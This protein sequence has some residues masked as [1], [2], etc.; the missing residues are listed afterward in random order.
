M[1]NVDNY[2]KLLLLSGWLNWIYFLL[3]NLIWKDAISLYLLLRVNQGNWLLFEKLK[4]N[5]SLKRKKQSVRVIREN[6]CM[7][8]EAVTTRSSRSQM[9]FKI[10]VLENFAIFTGKHPCW[11]LFK[12]K[13]QVRKPAA[14]LTRTLTQ[15]F[16]ENIM[17][18]LK[19]TFLI[20]HLRWLLLHCKLSLKIRSSHFY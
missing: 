14:L 5:Y 8:K 7:L 15:S 4:G 13:L 11:S 17:K 10:G 18:S 16:F 6:S 2:V 19:T 3:P 12:I 9:L 20:E 1:T